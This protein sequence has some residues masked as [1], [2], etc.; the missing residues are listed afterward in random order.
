MEIPKNV[1]GEDQYTQLF[2]AIHKKQNYLDID[3]SEEDFAELDCPYDR[4]ERNEKNPEGDFWDR[5][6][7]DGKMYSYFGTAPI[8]TVYYPIY[9]FT[10][11]IPTPLFAS[12]ILCLYCIIFMSLLYELLLKHFC[13]D[14]PREMALLGLI[15][16]IF[17]SVIFPVALETKFY[18]IA[19]LSGVSSVSAFFY[20]LFSAYFARNKSDKKKRVIF[21]VLAGIS[22]VAIVASRPT[23]VLY[24]FIALIPAWYIFSDKKESLK[25]KI[26]YSIA[27]GVPI[28]TG[29][30]MI[31]AYNYARF[32]NP[33]E[34][35]FNY[36]L[37]VS[38]AAANTIKLSM[39]PAAIYHYFIQQPQ[40]ISSF[41]YLKMT[42]NGFDSYERYSY[43]GITMGV[44]MY[45]ASWGVFA[46]PFTLKLKSKDKD[47][48]FK[49]LIILSLSVMVVLMAF[50]DMCK[51]GS[52]YRYTTDISFVLI[53][54]SLINIIDVSAMFKKANFKFYKYYY[55][56]V[57]L[58]MIITIFVGG[59]LAFN[60]ET[61]NMLKAY[62][63]ATRTIRI[64]I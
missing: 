24:C 15:A 4:S 25:N 18:Y 17:G 32:D 51:A 14:I 46:D 19:V 33:F 50:I 31:M 21:L 53:L 12:E 1:T 35:G 41:P 22:V 27:I 29:A 26:H 30:I 40:T 47:E 10:H 36:Q 42:Y 43:H 23:L 37:T 39:I 52:H 45:P 60:N 7:Y 48:K 57:S 16:L 13:K 49:S 20:F 58:L 62:D 64:F 59:L 2:D 34:F 55:A 38:R 11:R 9:M 56:I 63:L 5:A 61:H 6:Y 8:F 3:F 44:L 28:V 54:V